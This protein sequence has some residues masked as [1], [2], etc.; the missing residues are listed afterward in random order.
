MKKAP[1]IINLT[2]LLVI[3]LISNVI[4]AADPNPP[5]PLAPPEPPGLPI[6]GGILILGIAA[7]LYSFYFFR[8]RFNYSK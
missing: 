8:K 6:D 1:K 5:V 4:S 7:V 3:C 2:L